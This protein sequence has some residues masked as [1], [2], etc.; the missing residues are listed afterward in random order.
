MRKF[1]FAGFVGIILMTGCIG[2]DK[3]RKWNA[4]G[5]GKVETVTPVTSSTAPVSS[6]CPCPAKAK[7]KAKPKVSMSLKQQI[8]KELKELDKLRS[9]LRGEKY[10][11]L[12]FKQA[13]EKAKRRFERWQFENKVI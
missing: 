7:S 4:R 12:E 9:E 10:C 3:P 8:E 11:P 6:V 5:P 1:L 13:M 2:S